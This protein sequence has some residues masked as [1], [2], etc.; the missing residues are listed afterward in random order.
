MIVSYKHKGNIQ[1]G[2]SHVNVATFS[3]HVNMLQTSRAALN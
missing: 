2:A 3:S 1:S